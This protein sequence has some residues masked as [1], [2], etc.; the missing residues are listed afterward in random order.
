MQVSNLLNRIVFMHH[1]F[2]FA[3]YYSFGVNGAV[4]NSAFILAALP[5]DV[6]VELLS[7]LEKVIPKL[8]N[9]FP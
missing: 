9:G 1:N 7:E 8:S 5:T 3:A 2:C 6:E 4:K